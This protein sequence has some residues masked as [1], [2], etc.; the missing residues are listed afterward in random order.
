MATLSPWQLNVL[1]EQAM[2]SFGD[3]TYYQLGTQEGGQ[4]TNLFKIPWQLPKI[5]FLDAGDEHVVLVTGMM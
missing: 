1:D 2:Y 5:K 3:N 4:K